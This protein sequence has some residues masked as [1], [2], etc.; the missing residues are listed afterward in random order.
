MESLPDD[1]YTII[2]RYAG[3]HARVACSS[4]SKLWNQRTINIGINIVAAKHG[5]RARELFNGEFNLIHES[6]TDIKIIYSDYHL[7]CRTVTRKSMSLSVYSI[8][9]CG[10]VEVT[11]FLLVLKGVIKVVN[12]GVNKSSFVIVRDHVDVINGAFRSG[13]PDMIDFVR[14]FLTNDMIYHSAIN[15]RDALYNIDIIENSTIWLR[16]DYDCIQ[17]LLKYAYKYSSEADFKRIYVWCRKKLKGELVFTV[18]EHHEYHMIPVEFNNYEFKDAMIASDQ[19]L[20]YKTPATRISNSRDLADMIFIA[21]NIKRTNNA[22]AM[23]ELMI[24]DGGT[25]NS[26]DRMLILLVSKSKSIPECN[27]AISICAGLGIALPPLR[28]LFSV[29]QV[30]GSHRV[31]SHVAMLADEDPESAKVTQ[32]IASK[33]SGD[34]AYNTTNPIE[35][36]IMFTVINDGP[37]KSIREM[38]KMISPTQHFL[39][40]CIYL[41]CR[42]S[43]RVHEYFF[44]MGASVCLH[45]GEISHE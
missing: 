24:E 41:A 5:L 27:Y 28:L 6:L 25:T 17:Q 33:L 19:E 7:L 2:L 43:K 10:D 16:A 1:I 40:I 12:P 36:T 44:K 37:F 18:V 39:N 29:A 9:S 38:M 14:R 35:I 31:I 21:M 13:N 42:K 45:C 15:Y 34:L 4:L 22:H 20:V 32:K 8:C 3:G 23:L 11:L 30:K 26:L